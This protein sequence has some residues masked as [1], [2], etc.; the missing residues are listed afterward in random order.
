MAG[1]AVAFFET[2]EFLIDHAV[3]LMDLAEVLEL[4]G[5]RSPRRPCGSVRRSRSS[6]GRAT[7]CL[8][9]GR[10]DLWNGSP[11]DQRR[12]LTRACMLPPCR[13]GPGTAEPGTL[14]KSH[15]LPC[16]TPSMFVRARADRVTRG[17]GAGPGEVRPE[18]PTRVDVRLVPVDDPDPIGSRPRC[19]P[20]LGRCE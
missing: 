18:L 5:K 14:A 19:F 13:N 3:A 7:S 15:A 8:R 17:L 20:V 11:V 9:P 2:T 1:G 10:E 16:L 4:S 12:R 6:S